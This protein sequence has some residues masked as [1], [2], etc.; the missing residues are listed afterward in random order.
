[1]GNH[2]QHFTSSITGIKLP[3]KFTYPFYYDPHPLC[4]LAAKELQDYLTSQTDWE[5]NFGLNPQKEGTPLGKMF[6][7]LVVENQNQELGYL[8][9]VSGK[10]AAT[11]EHQVFVPPVFDM[12]HQGSYF[13]KEEEKLNQIN[14]EIETLEQNQTYKKLQAAYKKELVESQEDIA[15]KRLQGKEAKINRDQRRQKGKQH[16]S[17]EAHQELCEV[18]A[19]ESLESKY[20][21]NNVIRYW[22]HRLA[23]AQNAVSV[24]DDRLNEL[25]A[26]RKE[27]SGNLQ[28]F[29]FEQYQF[30]N[31]DGKVKNLLNLFENQKPP[32]GAGECAAPKLLQYAFEKKLKPI[33]MAE[34]WW[35][36]SPNTE[37]RKH[38][39]F[40]PACQG[41]CK[42]I[43]THM[44]KGL[45]VDTNPLLQ[46]P[47]VGK[48]IEIVFEDDVM[49]IVN[50]PAEFLSVPGI[51]IQDSV[52]SRIKKQ[53]PEATGALIVH[54]LDMSTSGLLILAK[55]KEAN[56]QLQ[57]QFISKSIKKR[58]V[59]V[60]DGMIEGNKGKI[61]LPLR[62]DL[63]D[64]PRQLVCFEHGKPATT[65][66]EKIDEKDGKTRV[67]LYPISGRTH[68]LRVHTS[69]ILGLNTAIVGD[70]LYGS[71]ADRL[72]LHAESIEFTHPTSLEKMRIKIAPEF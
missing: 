17:T 63:D 8:A 31:A 52:Y 61:S 21:L 43:L 56:K 72:H 38:Q 9:A 30:L 48:E 5:H 12:L 1:M 40:Y 7:V 39:H 37:I 27:K 35:G 69:H 71:K 2:F 49:L 41:K 28:N 4:E 23:A 67:Y 62:V 36:Q 68:Q 53:Y 66:W 59:A 55:T 29:L 54:R 13:L 47:A 22:E 19:K 70:D 34:F 11:N 65:Y 26:E 45:E 51:V 18:L 24:Y 50:K 32:A 14:L 15:A 6:G 46:N 16:L 64:R 10:L 58:Y 44:L 57:E 20:F 60:L 3:K 42:P 25:K 33:A